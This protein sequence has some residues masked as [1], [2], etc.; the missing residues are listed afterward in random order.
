MKGAVP[1]AN[2]I[3]LKANRCKNDVGAGSDSFYVVCV[4]L[5]DRKIILL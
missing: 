4:I 3:A 5:P 2:K 1:K